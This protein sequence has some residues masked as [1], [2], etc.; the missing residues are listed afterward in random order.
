MDNIQARQMP[1]QI[2]N[3]E[4]EIINDIRRIDFGRVTLSIQNGVIVSK[5]IT[6]VT[7]FC[8]CKNNNSNN[9]NNFL[10]SKTV[11]EPSL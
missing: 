8:K 11:P 1:I 6:I 10:K 9:S 4:I 5:E 7:K 3:E 2:S